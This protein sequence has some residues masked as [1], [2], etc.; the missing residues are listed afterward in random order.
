MQRRIFLLIDIQLVILGKRMDAE[1]PTITISDSPTSR[2]LP[3]PS[4]KSII[5]NGSVFRFY[6][7]SVPQGCAEI[8]SDL[9]ARIRGLS[10]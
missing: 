8:F 4:T 9:H 6:G 7:S 1:D 2:L 3:S 10:G 5:H